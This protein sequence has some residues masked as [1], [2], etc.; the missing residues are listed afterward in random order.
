[1]VAIALASLIGCVAV[2]PTGCA[3][4]VQNTKISLGPSGADLAAAVVGVGA[5]VVGT[6]VII[7]VHN[8]HHTVKGCVFSDPNGLQVQSEGDLKTY[9]LTGETSNIRVGDLVRF[10]GTKLK[11]VK[12]SPGNRIFVVEKVTRDY[13]PCRLAP[14][15][16]ANTPNAG[17]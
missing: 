17:R 12:S 16:T 8:S 5:V 6:V 4:G 9:A 3:N 15:H 1:M 13:G 2:S 14:G 7:K 10:H 11:K